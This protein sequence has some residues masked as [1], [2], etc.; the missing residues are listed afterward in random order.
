[1]ATASSV[2]ELAAPGALDRTARMAGIDVIEG[3]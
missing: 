2:A 1:M 3:R